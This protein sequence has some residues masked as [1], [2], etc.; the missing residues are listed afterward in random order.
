[1]FMGF[2]ALNIILKYMTELSQF[3]EALSLNAIVLTRYKTTQRMK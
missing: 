2:L 1:M 3:V